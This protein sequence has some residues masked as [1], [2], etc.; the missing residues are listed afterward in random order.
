MLDSAQAIIGLIASLFMFAAPVVVGLLAGV[1]MFFVGSQR[2]YLLLLLYLVPFFFFSMSTYGALEAGG[3]IWHRGSGLLY[4]P[5]MTWGLLCIYLLTWYSDKFNRRSVAT[6][7][8]HPWFLGLGL[9]FAAHLC[10]AA[11][12]GESL[13]SAA[14]TNG[15]RNLVLSGIF[16]ALLLRIFDTSFKLRWL[17][18]F[19]VACT[20]ARGLFGVV[21]FLFLGGD[22][23]NVY[24]NV[25]RIAVKLTFFDINDSLL[26][27][28]VI[29][30]CAWE[31]L[32]RWKNLPA[33]RRIAYLSATG[34]EA[35]IV[36]FSYRR[37]A[38]G[39][40]LA[41][42]LY[43]AWLLPMRKRV[44][45]MLSALPVALAGIAYV[46]SKRLGGRSLEDIV[47]R[48]LGEF[49]GQQS[50]K[51]V[52]QR[53]YE[54]RLAWQA[55]TDSP[56]FGVGSWG[57]YHTGYAQIGWQQGDHAF[58]FLHSGFLH[59]LVKTGLLG[60]GLFVG[61]ICA[62]T[63]IVLRVKRHISPEWQGAFHVG[64]AGLMFQ[65]PNWLV[66]TP[67]PEF[68]TMQLFALCLALPL[69]VHRASADSRQASGQ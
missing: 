55:F 34:I 39:G 49:S 57:A 60:F 25:E 13:D 53:E 4:L 65:I 14:H 59:I 35:F 11:I 38:W 9:L 62:F 45:A 28:I 10:M 6:T 15:F 31:L 19:L 17:I 23:A 20:V 61:L 5:I 52:S 29:F 48:F 44:V 7:P 64:I 2:P 21:R 54:L 40:L 27:S 51:G 24:E 16:Y 42:L 33:W 3:T 18:D 43:L 69:L 36:L 1:T 66:G 68:R 63:A 41:V 50:F 26:A 58:G 32:N 46:A 12:L 22:P 37:T 47:A 30:F 8:L 56:I 67:I